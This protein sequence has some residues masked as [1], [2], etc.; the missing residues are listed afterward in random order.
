[1]FQLYLWCC[2]SWMMQELSQAF[3]LLLKPQEWKNF[4]K[5]TDVTFSELLGP[6]HSSSTLDYQ[7][8][9]MQCRYKACEELWLSSNSC[10]CL[11]MYGWVFYCKKYVLD[12]HVARSRLG[13]K[14]LKFNILKYLQ[15]WNKTSNK[16]SFIR[17]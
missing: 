15:Q 16:N 13:L 2:W 6:Q 14:L 17:H 11:L 4:G 1:M 10:S 12:S 7:I 5:A 9:N 8:Q 3:F